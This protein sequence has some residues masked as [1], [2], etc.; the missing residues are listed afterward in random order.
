MEYSTKKISSLE[1]HT[2]VRIDIKDSSF[3]V[4]ATSKGVSFSGRSPVL[5]TQDDLASLA[6]IVDLAYREHVKLKPK[7]EIIKGV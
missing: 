6:K 7:I 1:G 3:R 5:F 4:T 2:E